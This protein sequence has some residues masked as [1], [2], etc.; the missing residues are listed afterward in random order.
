MIAE[1][2]KKKSPLLSSEVKLLVAQS[3]L[4]LCNPMDYSPPVSSIQEILQ[5]RILE[6]VAI[7]F[8]RGSSPPRDQIPGIPAKDL[9]HCRQIIYHPSYQ[10]L[11]WED[12]TCHGATKPVN[13]NY[14]AYALEPRNHNYWAHVPQLLKPRHPR[15]RVL[16]QEKPLQWEARVL[17]QYINA[18]IWNLERW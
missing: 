4:T 5:A 7:P 8:S 2:N 11:V 1:P 12:P 13:Y 16:Q 10:S 14:W 18:Y 9:L 3:Y 17:Q 6:W 15:A